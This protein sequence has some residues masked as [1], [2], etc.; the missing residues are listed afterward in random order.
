MEAVMGFAV[1]VFRET[2]SVVEMGAGIVVVIVPAAVAARKL[3]TTPE[4]ATGFAALVLL[5]KA[6]TVVETEAGIVVVLVP[7]AERKTETMAEAA[8][9][10]AG[11]VV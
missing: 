4:A 3:E 8:V 11:L 1:P 10:S 2:Q 5:R 9:G 7:E 6:R